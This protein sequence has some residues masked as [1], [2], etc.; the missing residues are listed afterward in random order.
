MMS[1]VPFLCA[2]LAA[3]A[4][5]LD[6]VV[7]SPL[8]GLAPGD[9]FTQYLCNGTDALDWCMNSKYENCDVSTHTQGDCLPSKG[10]HSLRATCTNFD[11]QVTYEIYAESSDC[12][13][14]MQKQFQ[15]VDL[16][17]Q[18]GGGE[19]FVKLECGVSS[20]VQV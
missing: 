10:G 8:T 16:C 1:R 13:G 18:G 3:A 4:S 6:T 11:A 20:E 9:T 12:S 17:Q 19:Y 2:T 7:P 15:V 14:A 5:N